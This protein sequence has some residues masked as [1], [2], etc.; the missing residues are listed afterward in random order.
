ML[1]CHKGH[2]CTSL[3]LRG[4]FRKPSSS[5]PLGYSGLYL[6]KTD[7]DSR[8][9]RGPAAPHH[10]FTFMTSKVEKPEPRT[11]ANVPHQGDVQ[12]LNTGS[13]LM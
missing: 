8:E 10:H 9:R 6:V 5:A 7:S 1:W 4:A 2:R 13:G 12:D 11:A 3:H